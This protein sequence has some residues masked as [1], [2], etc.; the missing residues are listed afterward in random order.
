MKRAPGFDVIVIGLG[1]MGSASAYQL[2]RRGARVLGIDRFEPP[3]ER[4]SSHGHSR[5]TRLAVGEGAQYVPLVQRSHVIWRE[6][7][8]EGAGELMVQTGG[9]VIGP[10]DGRSDMHGQHDFVSS[11]IDVAQRLGIA[12]EVWDAAGIAAHFPQFVVAGNERAYFEPEA[13][14]LRPE[15]CVAAQLE[16]ARRLGAHIVTGHAVTGLA[17]EGDSVVV[18]TACGHWRAARAVLTAGA[19]NP[20]LAGGRYAEQLA[21]HRQLLHWFRPEEPA[22]YVPGR[23]PVFIWAHGPGPADAFYGVPMADGLAGLKVGT[24]QYETHTDPDDLQRDV[25]DAECAAM[26]AR[27]VSG[28]LHG[29]SAQRVHA[30]ACLYTVAPGARF[31]IDRH[32]QIEQVTVVSACSGHGFKH[33]AALGEALA[34]RLLAGVSTIDL[35]PFAWPA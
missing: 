25:A 31:I 16:Q 8:A 7:E 21:V 20:A 27:H 18:T 15:R 35:S 30:A 14:L 1:A 11:T 19:W 12:H 33:S 9:L 6:L 28:R 26:H 24:Q 34:E 29:V 2:A 5:I 13:G 17:A 32:P 3:H 23:C 22:L 10:A 4:G